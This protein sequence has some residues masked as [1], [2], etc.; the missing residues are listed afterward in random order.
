MPS[1]ACWC[2]AYALPDVERLERARQRAGQ[3]VAA[4][5]AT[6]VEAPS[7]SRLGA[8]STWAPETERRAEL[9]Q[10]WHLDVLL[11]AR[12]GYG[13]VHLLPALP[14]TGPAPYLIGY[15]DVT[16]LHA[17]WWRRGWGET[18]YGFM[19]ATPG[20]ARSL[21]TT[22]AL[23]RGEGLH[24][25]PITDPEVVVANPGSGEGPCFAACLRVLTG[26]CGTPEQPDLHGAVL[27]IEDI[28]ERAYQVDRDLQQLAASGVLRGIVGLV[29]GSFRANEPAG[30]QG[31]DLLALATT[32][33]ERL[34]VPTVVGL[35][36]GHESD[37]L[38]L[39]CG[40][41]TE[42]T[43]AQNSWQLIQASGVAL[44]SARRS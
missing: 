42:L 33:G 19:P 21:A 24:L 8:P 43:A 11:A 35:P 28:D 23:A 17:A 10:L 5:D 12:G 3:L 32:W 13:C 41:R 14:S 22:I 31:P 26:L 30:Y 7:L 34:N 37:A 39:A 18:L 6:L 25:D 29:F 20:G 15:S 27:A 44:G 16:V 38:T 36:F 4:L 1:V 2:P 9:A 40:R